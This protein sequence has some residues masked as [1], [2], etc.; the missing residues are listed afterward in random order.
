MNDEQLDQLLGS[1]RSSEAPAGRAEA[2]R[3]A[4]WQRLTEAN[5]C[6]GFRH[7][8]A[9]YASGGLPGA[10]RLLVDDHLSR[11][12]HCRRALAD[13]QQP[14]SGE[15]VGKVMAMR[16]RRAPVPRWASWAAAAGFAAVSLYASRGALDR[17]LAPTGPRARLEAAT[18]GVFLLAS[19]ALQVGEGLVSG[20]TIRTGAGAHAI[21]R[22]VDGS[23]VE[24]NERTEMF[25]ETAWSGETIQLERGDV[26]VEAAKQRLGHLRV[27]TRDSV[28]SV[29]GTVFAVSADAAG[30]LVSVVEGA[31][32]VEQPGVERVLAPGQNA[33]TNGALAQ[34]KVSQAVAWSDHAERYFSVLAALAKVEKDLAQLPA[35]P[36]RTEAKLVRYLPA[37]ASVYVAFPNLNGTIGQALN[38][39]DQRARESAALG[40][41]WSS[42]AGQEIRQSIERIQTVTPLLGDEIV[43]IVQSAVPHNGDHPVLLAQVRPGQQEA[44]RT[45][46]AQLAN[47]STPL[48]YRVTPELLLVAESSI[49]LDLA[50]AALGTGA[51]SAFAGQIRAR[52]AA[53]VGWLSAVDVV[54]LGLNSGTTAGLP[55]KV[56]GAGNMRAAFFEQKSL[57]GT[58]DL[59]AAITFNG[60]RTGMAS[61]LAAPGSAGAMEYATA[62]AQFAFAASTRSPRQA[63]DEL[64]ELVGPGAATTLGEFE[65]ETGLNVRSDIAGALGTDF[66]VSV[67][68]VTLPTPGWVAAAEVLQPTVLDS[69]LQKVVEAANRHLPAGAAPARFVQETISGR[70]WRLMQAASGGMELHWTYDRGYLIASTDR[71]LALRA[72]AMRDAGLTLPRSSAFRQAVPPGNLHHSG[73]I[74]VNANA[75]LADAAA[76]L[77]S[78]A[79]NSL[80]GSRTPVLVVLDSETEQ[81]RAASRTRL[82]SLVLDLLMSGR[83]HMVQKGAQ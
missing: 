32:A 42:A 4:V 55:A 23:R 70:A 53:G 57:G 1:V 3:D 34:I 6:A 19:H 21:L 7:D 24:L 15:L 75:A 14:A 18:G 81:I 72:I 27:V 67:E 28:A 59:S 17:A 79:L 8:F 66:V 46:L 83:V 26:L 40:E 56:L 5:L 30:S 45:A 25:L 74:W 62:E 38:L 48:P 33:A 39:F 58:D 78:P 2:A 64:L 52:Y 49:Q 31:V 61:W 41:W 73:Y 69:A 76:L 37:G 54:G 60:A 20:Q 16:P 51:S 71:A 29:K 77:N 50:A 80:V 13:F 36:L 65:M 12:A 43:V 11:C 22:L 10:R 47:G 35:Q 9:A 63:F 44:L 68:R 82:T